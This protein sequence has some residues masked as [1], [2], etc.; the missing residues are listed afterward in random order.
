VREGTSQ[1]AQEPTAQCAD[2]LSEVAERPLTGTPKIVDK[3][4]TRC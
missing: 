2:G 3:D 1:P 4:D